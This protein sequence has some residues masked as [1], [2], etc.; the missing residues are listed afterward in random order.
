MPRGVR[1]A[2]LLRSD[3]LEKTH[4]FTWQSELVSAR[5]PLAPVVLSTLG[6]ALAMLAV[7]NRVSV[8][9]A[10]ETLVV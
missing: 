10:A 9:C 4:D 1:R 6:P 3:N 5:K 8:F 7:L 2:R